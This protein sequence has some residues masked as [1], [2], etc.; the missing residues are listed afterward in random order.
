[1]ADDTI[2]NLDAVRERRAAAAIED[3]ERAWEELRLSLIVRM[4]ESFLSDGALISA[5]L[6]ALL[7][8]VRRGDSEADIA[9][10]KK[11]IEQTLA[12]FF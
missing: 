4:G 2:V 12:I 9:D 6:R 10:A 11:R 5:T 7:D 3:N 1:M 8:M